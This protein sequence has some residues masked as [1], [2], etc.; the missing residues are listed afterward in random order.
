MHLGKKRKLILDTNTASNEVTCICSCMLLFVVP[1]HLAVKFLEKAVIL[2]NSD[3]IL[4]V[5]N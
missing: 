5:I 2:G 4:Y 3:G 1:E